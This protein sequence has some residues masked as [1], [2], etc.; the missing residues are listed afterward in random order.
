MLKYVRSGAQE[1]VDIAALRAAKELGIPTGGWMPKGFKTTDGPKT[2]YAD[3][4]NLKELN[5]SY[6]ARTYKNVEDS[7]ATLIIA[8]KFDSPGTIC[9]KKAIDF[10]KKPHFLVYVFDPESFVTHENDTPYEAAK[11][12]FYY[13]IK[14]VNVAGNR[15]QIA[16][17]IENWAYRYVTKMIEELRKL[18]ETLNEDISRSN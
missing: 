9:T 4:Y 10:Y 2:E 14:C 6:Q 18:D 3:L 8:H 15:E 1:G 11:W 12:L 5:G 7:D 17:G 16:P 13:Q